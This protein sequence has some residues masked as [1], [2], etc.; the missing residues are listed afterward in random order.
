MTKAI[1]R[2]GVPNKIINMMNAIYKEPDY[3]LVDKDTTTDPRIQNKQ[4]LYKDAHHLY[5][6]YS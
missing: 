6:S 1:K 4:E 5:L 3:T 2:L